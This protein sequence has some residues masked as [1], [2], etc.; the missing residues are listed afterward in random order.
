MQTQEIIMEALKL[1]ANERSEI[2][3]RL[4][5]S[6]DKPDADIDRV[7]GEEAVRRARALD[8]GHSKTYALDEILTEASGTS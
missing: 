1:K 6:L 5:E 2:V 3:D 7:W 8:R 4:L